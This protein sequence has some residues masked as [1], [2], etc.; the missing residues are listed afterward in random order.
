VQS[1]VMPLCQGLLAVLAIS[2]V[3]RLGVWP[4]T[5]ARLPWHW[6]LAFT[7]LA[8]QAAVNI[9]VQ[10]VLLTGSGSAHSL[11]VLAGTL[12]AV[13]LAGH[14][15]APHARSTTSLIASLHENKLPAAILISAWL[16]N[17]VVALALST[18]IDELYYHMLLPKR[19]VED[20]GLRFYLLPLEQAILPQMHFQ[21]TLSM[22]HATGAP[23]AGNVLSWAYSVVLGLFVAGFLMEAT[24]RARPGQS[25]AISCAA[26]CTVGLY[27][28]VWHTTGGAHALGDLAT[29]IAVAGI[30]WP[31]TLMPALGPTRYTLLL[32]TAASI[33][34]S[35]KL[36]LWP[37]SAVATVLIVWR[38][39]QAAG[40]FKKTGV[41]AAI[42]AFSWLIIHA[43]VMIW[44]YRA[45]GSFWGPVFANTLA[46]TV[47]P[48]DVLQE[49]RQM[50][51]F[52][53]SAAWP[54]LQVALIQFSPVFFVS[55]AWVLWTAWRG[56][57]ASRLA[58]ALLLFQAVLIAWKLHFDF[59][60]MGGLEYAAVLAAAV[61]LV[62]PLEPPATN[63]RHACAHWR[64]RLERSRNWILLFAAVP[65]LAAQIY[66]ARP[67]AEV[68]SGWMP[69]T[70][71]LER[72]VALTR[73]FEA[74]DRMLPKNAVL[75]IPIAEGRL[76]N[77]Y[78]PRPVVTTPLD[79]HGRAP[80]YR[81]TL[82]PGPAA[83]PIDQ[84]S[85]LHCGEVLYSNDHATVETYRTPGAA[86]I[87][88]IVK[89]QS[90]EVEPSGLL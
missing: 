49:L 11:R 60:F 22:A 63:S 74:L 25:M 67:F 1:F 7:M 5:R 80:V 26:L 54:L 62:Q 23:D 87:T 79:L 84:G 17:L 59:R 61:T 14:L 15:F 75:Y 86:P 65:W 77:F 38:A 45:S 47:F 66:Y 42:A 16:A 31:E 18:K 90:C 68:V 85:S 53:P 52:D 44:T 3:G 12:L 70:Q 58:A 56:C 13:A 19:I 33:A 32:V 29:T 27:A 43:P 35:T 20:G 71:F 73:D 40:S 2:G 57:G 82:E 83:E 28:T 55:L 69:R 21:M 78:A 36:S 41:S 30:L 81:L 88:G 4:I 37:L 39:A 64:K 8:G 72:Y 46:P 9:L 34:A 50:Q 10:A 24:D 76:P 6:N 89:V 48:T 51:Q